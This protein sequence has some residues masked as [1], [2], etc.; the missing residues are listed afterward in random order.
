[1]ATDFQLFPSLPPELRLHIW[2]IALTTSWSCTTIK[3]LRRYN[4]KSTGTNPTKPITQVCHEARV[5]LKETHTYI[6]DLGLFNFPKHI[7]FIRDLRYSPALPRRLQ[8]RYSLF[9]YIQH[10]VINPKSRTLM[11]EIIEFLAEVAT[12]LKSIVVVAPWFLPEDTDLYDDYKDWIAPYEDFGEVFVRSPSEVNLV[13]LISAIECGEDGGECRLLD[14]LSVGEYKARLDRAVRRLP[15]PLPDGLQ[16]MN[17]AYWR[18]RGMLR[19]VEAAV[20]KFATPPRLYLQTV[21]NMRTSGEDGAEG[22]SP[23]NTERKTGRVGAEN[24]TE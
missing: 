7:F 15:D 19:T 17:N 13:N 20:G 22:T 9:S 16:F 8:S 10:I 4:Y 24:V 2:H 12:D 23:L 5:A 1:M 11:Y 3:P 18:T 6:E 21:A 14:G